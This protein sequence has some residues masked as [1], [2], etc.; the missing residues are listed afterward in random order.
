[1]CWCYMLLFSA[2]SVQSLKN[3]LCD[4]CRIY[5]A[6][7]FQFQYIKLRID[8]LLD[9][10]KHTHEKYRCTLQARKNEGDNFY[11]SFDCLYTGS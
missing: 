4:V 10:F 11:H 8:K 6:K 7:R 9:I 5:V 2:P 1:M 3:F